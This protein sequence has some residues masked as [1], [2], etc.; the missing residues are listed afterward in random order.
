MLT[1]GCFCGAVRYEAR[2]AP[3]HE[4]ICHCADCRRM[5]GAAQV[6]W[7][8]VPRA[9]FRFVAGTPSAFQSSSAVLRRFCGTCGTSLTYE[10]D[11]AP[12]AIDVTIASLD[13]LDQVP[14]RDHTRMGSKVSWDPVGDGLPAFSG[15]RDSDSPS[16]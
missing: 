3:F 4:T 6:A 1:G 5:V 11:A 15:A 7:F 9:A 14:P 16:G 10:V 2:A 13:E 8:S 12:D